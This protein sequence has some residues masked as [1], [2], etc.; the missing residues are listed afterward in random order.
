MLTLEQFQTNIEYGEFENTD[1]NKIVALNSSSIKLG[2][3]NLNKMDLALQNKYFVKKKAFDFGSEFH[4]Y[5]FEP[6][7]FDELY[8]ISEKKL[9]LRK[10]ADKAIA[11]KEKIFGGGKIRV[12]AKEA[13]KIKGMKESLYKHPAI[14]ELIE[15]EGKIEQTLIWK[16]EIFN[17]N[18]KGR[19]DKLIH[20]SKRD[21]SFIV[22]LKTTKDSSEENFPRDFRNYGYGIQAA[23]YSDGYKSLFGDR[24]LE[25]WFIAIDKEYPYDCET[26]VVS[27]KTLDRYREQYKQIISKY[28]NYKNNPSIIYEPKVL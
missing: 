23:F 20:Q 7:K 15:T 26:Y 6:E 12:D 11:L 17:V 2:C 22:D 21:C 14:L 25:F 10:P 9:D 28:I 16:N 19:F 1:Y 3:K 8:Q 5:L 27:E 24:K 4:Y 13:V 18:C